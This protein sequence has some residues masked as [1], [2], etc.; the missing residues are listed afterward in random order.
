[1]GTTQQRRT[2]LHKE[3]VGLLRGVGRHRQ[4]KPGPDVLLRGVGPGGPVLLRL[5]NRDGKHPL[6]DL[7]PPH[8]HLHQGQRREEL[9]PQWN[10]EHTRHTAQSQLGHEIHQLRRLLCHPSSR[11]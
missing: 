7:L 8:R 9:P 11:L 10:S 1:M 3:R 4:R 2:A 6:R 5:P